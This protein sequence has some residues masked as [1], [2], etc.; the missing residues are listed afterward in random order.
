MAPK[1]IS[2]PHKSKGSESAFL[3]VNE[4]ASTVTRA[5]KDPL[6]DREKQSHVQR[7]TLQLRRSQMKKEQSHKP[8]Q[9]SQ[10]FEAVDSG[11]T[12]DYDHLALDAFVHFEFQNPYLPDLLPRQGG[13]LIRTQR[14]TQE[15]QS[16][17]PTELLPIDPRLLRP[18][19]RVTTAYRPGHFLDDTEEHSK[20]KATQSLLQRSNDVS[21]QFP[22]RARTVHPMF[23]GEFHI[24]EKWAP[25]LIKYYNTVLL[26]EKFWADTLKVPLSQTRHATAIHA[27]MQDVMSEPA[28]LYSFLA[29]ASSQMLVREGRLLLP[30]QNLP[31][32]RVPLFFKTKAIGAIRHL[33]AK[34]V[35]NHRL[36]H[37]VQ[38][39][40]VHAY[41][42]NAYEAADPHFEA[43]VSM[44][45]SL[46]GIETFNVYFRETNIL[47]HWSAGLKKL[48][49]PRLPIDFDPGR[50][51]PVV[52]ST[53]DCMEAINGG[54]GD[55]LKELCE[56][57]PHPLAEAALQH[58]E[59]LRLHCWCRN[60]IIY[61]ARYYQWLSLRRLAIGYRL[62]S[63]GSSTDVQ[64]ECFRIALIFWTALTR[65]PTSG[66]RCSSLQAHTLRARL[67]ASDL[68]SLWGDKTDW[69]LWIAIIGA[70]TSRIQMDIQWF[71]IIAVR[72]ARALHVDVTKY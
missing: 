53:L 33:L 61:D 8:Q 1:P 10:A 3:F 52:S 72:A 23:S 54:T 11:A 30:D 35:M 40:I 28:A 63:M 4:D 6:L 18:Q 31:E 70:L 44:I 47:L 25:P 24:L 20:M 16:S 27:D 57:L 15:L 38:R 2:R 67:Q 29:S 49:P 32:D 12:S 45:Q 14:V 66:R 34:G 50:G 68:D 39:L 71:V 13:A 42:S 65:C 56:D 59:A 36:V 69:L 51:S 19:D 62:L 58:L 48:A 5:S 17:V 37:D 7:H 41:F 9:A 60:S 55:R 21:L 22:L 64:E 46:G 26:P 43:M